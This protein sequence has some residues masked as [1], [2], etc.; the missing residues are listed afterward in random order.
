MGT[1]HARAADHGARGRGA[2]EPSGRSPAHYYGRHREEAPHACDGQD[3]LH[4]PYPVGRAVAAAPRL[5]GAR[6][7]LR[8]GRPRA[9][10]PVMSGTYQVPVTASAGRS[11]TAAIASVTAT[12]PVWA[13]RAG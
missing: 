7:S 12:A 3:R 6:D 4:Q 5:R 8:P 1:H 10:V 11:A 2:D 13:H 9:R